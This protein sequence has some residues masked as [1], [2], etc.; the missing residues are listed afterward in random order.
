MS[1][2]RVLVVDDEEAIR[3]TLKQCLE[4][5][6]HQVSVCESG[7]EA[8]SLLESQD[9][10]LI[11]LDV[12]LPGVDGLKVLEDLRRAGRSEEVVMISGHSSIDTAVKAIRLG[13]FDF[14]EKPLSLDRVEVSVQ[15]AL[16]KVRLEE[17]N[18]ILREQLGPDTEIVGSSAPI[19]ALTEQAL[20]AAPTDGRVLI[21]GEN[22]TGKELIA[23]LIHAN[24]LRAAEA[25]VEVNCAAIPQ[26]LIES[27]L[28]GHRKGSFTGAFE[29]KKGKFLL[30]SGGTLFLD[31]V[32]DMS[33][34][35][36]A[37]VLRALQ[38]QTI[39]PVGGAG[40]VKVNVR[41]IAATNKD[42]PSEI[43]AGRFREDL[44]YRLNVVPLRVPPLRERREDIPLIA[45]HYL[46][47]FAARYGRP[48][49]RLGAEAREALAAYS[50]P[51]N[52]R[53]L[54]N[55]MERAVIMAPAAEL[56]PRDVAPGPSGQAAPV[57]Q[58][59][60]AMAWE[61]PIKE[62]REAFEREFIRR[63]LERNQGN[64]SRTAEELGIERR[65]LY[66]RLQALGLRKETSYDA[67]ERDQ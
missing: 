17:S 16:K 55:L 3:K 26:E 56:G 28:F 10:D 11:M 34:A 32:G 14:I 12:W 58:P 52:V 4:D 50:W 25:F 23:R 38:E 63:S 46:R 51:G 21:F 20:K 9:F 30:A 8:M 35:T 15:N 66:R 19:R 60:T 59:G 33:L 41:V 39:E 31:E 36:Q 18:R 45:E 24:S 27:E 47:S 62:A 40:S 61:G 53:E 48:A 65:H 44:Y 29:N 6:G 7:E 49:K 22:G 43:S 57:P 42:L 64:V 1:E 67:D 5:D 2:G 13:A 37:K 54:K